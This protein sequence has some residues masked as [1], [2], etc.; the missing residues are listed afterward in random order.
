MPFPTLEQ[1]RLS[2]V[3]VPHLPDVIDGLES[4]NPKMPGYV[5]DC[6]GM[7]FYIEK[8]PGD[9]V[10][11]LAGNTEIEDDISGLPE[12][13]RELWEVARHFVGDGS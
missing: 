5:Y 7:K 1:F 2:R 13:E 11:L 3:E 12:L 8:W 6:D 9:R 10:Y 4:P